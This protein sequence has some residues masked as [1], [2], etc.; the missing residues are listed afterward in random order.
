MAEIWLEMA[1]KRQLVSL[2]IYGTPSICTGIFQLF[3]HLPLS[4]ETIFG[5]TVGHITIDELQWS[6]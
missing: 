5:N 4:G 1:V 6:I 2:L 3:P